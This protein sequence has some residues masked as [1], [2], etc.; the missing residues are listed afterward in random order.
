[1]TERHDVTV[2]G[3]GL[4][5]LAAARAL[6]DDGHDAVVLEARDR[7]GGKTASEH[8]TYG[9]V[10]ELGGQWVGADQNRVRSLLDEFDIDTRSQY[11]EGTVI[12]RI[13]DD[14]T[15]ADSYDELLRSIPETAEAELFAALEEIERCVEQVPRDA[16][17]EAP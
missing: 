14:R 7:V 9:D 2:V 1:M 15:V 3:G 11:D 16:P 12:G 5:G 4:A 10:V 17:Q 13:G 6:R 8:T